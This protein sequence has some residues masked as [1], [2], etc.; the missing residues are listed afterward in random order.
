MTDIVAPE[1]RSRMMSSIRG[2]NTKP[3]LM[4]RRYLHACGLRFRLERKGLPCRPDLVMA[5]FNLVVLVHGCFW[6]RHRD[7]GYAT[8]PATRQAFWQDKFARNVERDQRQYREL[9]DAGWRVLVIWECGLKHDT[10]RIEEIVE[11][12]RKD[13]AFSEWPASPPRP[14]RH[15]QV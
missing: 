7:C 6:H 14:L 9:R 11:I 12:I 13:D 1:T 3:E 5:R 8:M 15:E 2:K 4:V 10:E